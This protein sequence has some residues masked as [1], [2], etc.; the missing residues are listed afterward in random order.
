MYTLVY[1]ATLLN[2]QSLVTSHTLLLALELLM[3]ILGTT[4]QQSC[5]VSR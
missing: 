1:I 5:Q 3:Y 4:K 2:G